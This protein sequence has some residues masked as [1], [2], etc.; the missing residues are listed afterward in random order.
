M[1]MRRAIIPASALEIV[2]LFFMGSLSVVLFPDI[3]RPAG[4]LALFAVIA[5]ATLSIS[6]LPVIARIRMDL[7]LAGRE[8]GSTILTAATIDDAI[9]WV[10]LCLCSEHR[11]FGS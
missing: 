7:N 10:Y 4:S 8:V 1:R 3:W 2:I 9:G 5:G 6:A 11:R